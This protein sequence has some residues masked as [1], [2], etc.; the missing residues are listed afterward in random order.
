MGLIIV[1]HLMFDRDSFGRASNE[2]IRK[3]RRRVPRGEFIHS[4]DLISEY[5]SPDSEFPILGALF[6]TSNKHRVSGPGQCLAQAIG[7][8]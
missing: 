6:K 7:A 3:H 4:Y 8:E 2:L 5:P 1:Y